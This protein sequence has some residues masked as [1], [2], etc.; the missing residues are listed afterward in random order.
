MNGERSHTNP[1][2]DRRPPWRS[3]NVYCDYHLRAS[4]LTDIASTELYGH[5]P[6]PCAQRLN[7]I[8]PSP[9]LAGSILKNAAADLVHTLFVIVPDEEM[10]FFQA[11][12]QS[13]ALYIFQL[14]LLCV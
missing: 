7:H 5:K 1:F 2:I 10:E 12:R 3:S 6:H 13:K 14:W 4:P 11:S 8:L 9:N